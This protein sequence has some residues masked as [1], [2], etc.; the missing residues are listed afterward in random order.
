MPRKLLE[1]HFDPRRDKYIERVFRSIRFETWRDFQDVFALMDN[2][3]GEQEAGGEFAIMAG[4]AHRDRYTAATHANLPNG[5]RESTIILGGC[6][7]LP[8]V[9]RLLTNC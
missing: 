9:L 7:S 2:S 8:F 1:I 5:L 3:F 6:I 4:R